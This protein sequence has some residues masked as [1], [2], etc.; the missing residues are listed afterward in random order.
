MIRRGDAGRRGLCLGLLCASGWLL[1]A[2]PADQSP[3]EP[4]AYCPF[5]K[6]GET[7]ACL[8]PATH[9]YQ[10]F[11]AELEAGAVSEQGAA[12]VEADLAGGASN[13]YL[14]LSS[15]AYGYFRLAQGAVAAERGDPETIARLERWNALLTRAYQ[16]SP[17]DPGFQEAV[18]EA[19]VDLHR[20]G[21][22]VELACLDAAGNPARCT[23]TESVVRTLSQQRDR[24]GMRGALGKLLQR[25]FG[26]DD[27]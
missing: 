12:R 24:A 1:A 13:R 14:A 10:E 20:R 3:P 16:A 2:A 5:P 18:R 26:S 17:E 11:F 19:A 15:L 7:P 4:G 9:A 27:S 25:L 23:S 8:Q 6:E 21:P 22:A